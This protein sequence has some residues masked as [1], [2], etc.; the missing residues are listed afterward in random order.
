M[1][2]EF[3]AFNRSVRMRFLPPTP[4]SSAPPCLCD[5]LPCRCG[6]VTTD[7]SCAPETAFLE[8]GADDGRAVLGNTSYLVGIN[9]PIGKQFTSFMT[10]STGF[11]APTLTELA[12]PGQ[13]GLAGDVKAENSTNAETGLSG[14]PWDGLLDF[15]VALYYTAIRNGLVPYELESQPGRRFFINAARSSRAGLEL[16]AN[17]TFDLRWS[18]RM[19]H[20]FSHYRFQDFSSGEGNLEGNALPLIPGYR[21]ALQISYSPSDEG[22]QGSCLVRYEGSFFCRQRQ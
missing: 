19:A 22:L 17:A 20:T 6:Y 18:V 9:V 15:Q 7:P 10:L 13:G 14:S 1:S 16:E 12:S 5:G 4:P 11:R 21:G 2:R 8:D 3:G